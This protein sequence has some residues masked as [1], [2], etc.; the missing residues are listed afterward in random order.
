[1]KGSER[2]WQGIRSK[3]STRVWGKGRLA[4]IRGGDR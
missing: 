2:S 4:S 1:M 3:F